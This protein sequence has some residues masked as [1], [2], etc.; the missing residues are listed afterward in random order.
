[1]FVHAVE[2]FSGANAKKEFVMG[3]TLQIDIIGTYLFIL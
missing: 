1:M 2:Y 3:G